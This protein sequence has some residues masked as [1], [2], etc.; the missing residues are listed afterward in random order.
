VETNAAVYIDTTAKI[1]FVFLTIYVYRD[2][3]ELSRYTNYLTAILTYLK[4]SDVAAYL[5]ASLFA[6]CTTEQCVIE[7]L[8]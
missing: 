6:T 3:P 4:G 1:S 2:Q 8:S 7:Y 5:S